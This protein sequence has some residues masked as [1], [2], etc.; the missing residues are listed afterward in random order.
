MVFGQRQGK[1]L[2]MKYKYYGAKKKWLRMTRSL[3]ISLPIPLVI[4]GL[5][6]GNYNLNCWSKK[7]IAK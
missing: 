5:W 2:Q 3:A 7:V 4:R 1:F 6:T